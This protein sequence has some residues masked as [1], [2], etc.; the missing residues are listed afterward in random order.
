MIYVIL[1]KLKSPGDPGAFLLQ[2]TAMTEEIEYI[3]PNIGTDLDGVKR[4]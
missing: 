1:Q 4:E 3:S 2:S